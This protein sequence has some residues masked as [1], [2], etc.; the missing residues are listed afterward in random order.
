LIEVDVV[1][2]KQNPLW[3][4]RLAGFT[5]FALLNFTT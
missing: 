2:G 3:F 5:T 4:I 1:D